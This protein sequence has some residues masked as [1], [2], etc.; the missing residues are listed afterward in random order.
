[1]STQTVRRYERLGV[2]PSVERSPNGY[3]RY[4]EAHLQALRLVRLLTEA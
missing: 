1:V 2:I 4:G 3:R